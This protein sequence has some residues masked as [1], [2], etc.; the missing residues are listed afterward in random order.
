MPVHAIAL[1]V[2]GLDAALLGGLAGAL[3]GAHP[4]RAGWKARDGRS[5]PQTA[6]QR[7]TGAL[8]ASPRY[9]ATSN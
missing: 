5:G 7:A 1:F 9:R 2:T 8:A 6:P 3:L 4:W